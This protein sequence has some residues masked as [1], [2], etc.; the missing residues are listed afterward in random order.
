MPPPPA[1]STD[2]LTHSGETKTLLDC[3]ECSKQFVALIDY[4]L[5][6]EHVVECPHCGH[7]HYRKI[8]GGKVTEARW[9]SANPR[10]GANDSQRTAHR[11]RRVWKSSVDVLQMKTS[12]ASEFLRQRWIEKGTS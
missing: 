4:S 3:N 5:N 10:P 9:R 8:E 7:E 2:R 1:E 6:G 11:A 12:S